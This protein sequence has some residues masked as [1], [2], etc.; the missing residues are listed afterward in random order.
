MT[1][2]SASP[3]LLASVSA[4]R[5]GKLLIPVFKVENRSCSW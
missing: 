2:T 3:I 5:T 4:S 1:S